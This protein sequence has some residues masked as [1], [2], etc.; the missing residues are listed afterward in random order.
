MICNVYARKI[1]TARTIV[2]AYSR[3]LCGLVV[4]CFQ[5]IPCVY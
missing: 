2:G 1:K 5:L 3:W 4:W